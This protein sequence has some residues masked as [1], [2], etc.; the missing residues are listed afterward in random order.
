[1]SNW[2]K[3]PTLLT[4]ISLKGAVD[5]SRAACIGYSSAIPSKFPGS[6]N[7]TLAATPYPGHL[8]Y[9]F[10]WNC[11]SPEKYTPHTHAFSGPPKQVLPADNMCCPGP[12]PD[13]G[14]VKF[15]ERCVALGNSDDSRE[16]H[17]MP[18]CPGKDT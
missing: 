1:M 13:F 9:G 11:L 15:A 3:H 6:T 4:A 12:T 2:R 14:G 10:R 17:G 16:Y 18:L 8:S 5:E 7:Y